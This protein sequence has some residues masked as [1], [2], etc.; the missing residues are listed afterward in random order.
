M[1]TLDEIVNFHFQWID[2][3]LAYQEEPVPKRILP[4]AIKFV[5]ECIMD[6]NIDPNGWNPGKSSDFVHKR[7][8]RIFHSYAKQWYEERYGS[9]LRNSELFFFRSVVLIA[10]TPFGLRVPV[11]RSKPEVEGETAVLFWP[12]SVSKEENPLDWVV[13]PPNFGSYSS[14]ALAKA[15]KDSTRAANRIRAI[16]CRFIGAELTDEAT[17]AVLAGVKIHLQ[18][19][20][21]LIL[22]EDED[23]RLPR[24]QWE[25]Q[26]ACESAYKGVL[27]QRKGGFP[28]HH[29][30]F[31]LNREAKPFVGRVADEWLRELPRWTEA[32]EL[33]YGL[34]DFTPT[35]TGIVAWYDTTLKIVSG[36]LTGLEGLKLDQASITFKMPPWFR[37]YDDPA[38]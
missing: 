17:R 8:F 7:W 16:S 34:G 32:A 4:A 37:S 22:R 20:A 29:D 23:G 38:E 1:R 15:R 31:V 25:L 21:S 5:E 33:R 36:V 24:A 12:G 11:T 13:D 18:S 35:I 19:A 6:S 14:E 26:M 2:E 30:L 3:E 28:P 27:Q 9:R 10:G